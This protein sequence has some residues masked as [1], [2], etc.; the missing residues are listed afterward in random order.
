M[1]GS[2]KLVDHDS[3]ETTDEALLLQQRILAMKSPDPSDIRY[4]QDL[5]QHASMGPLALIGDDALVWGTA[6][7]SKD[8][9][10]DLITLRPR[11]EADFFSKWLAANAIKVITKCGVSRWWKNDP[12]NGTFSYTDSSIFRITFWIASIL[13]SLLP[14]LF[15]AALQHTSL[16][17]SRMG[18]I[19]ACNVLLSA[20][21]G[22]FTEARKV[23][24][25]AVIAVYVLYLIF[26]SE[27]KAD[28]CIGILSVMSSWS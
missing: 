25:F 22:L 13:A 17:M 6:S 26:H 9:A 23:D 8:H 27:C 14:V 18:T 7:K 5:L 10:A 1:S 12:V 19:I 15:L 21:L 4:M 2:H 28:D 24:I 3:P 11:H 20:C 16:H